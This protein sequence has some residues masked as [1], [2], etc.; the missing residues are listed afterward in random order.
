MELVDKHVK[1]SEIMIDPFNPRYVDGNYDS[2]KNIIN[3]ILSKKEAY[4]L[5][6][7]MQTKVRWVNRIVLREIESLSIEKKSKICDSDGYKYIIVEGNTRLAC[8]KSGQIDGYNNDTKIPVV[9]TVRDK[10]EKQENFELEI[11]FIQAMANIMIVKDWEEIPKA[12]RIYDIFTIKKELQPNKKIREIIIDISESTGIP[13]KEVTKLINRYSIFNELKKQHCALDEKYWGF[14]EAFERS[15]DSKEF[16]GMIPKTIEFEWNCEEKK[17]IFADEKLEI[18]RNIPEIIKKA[19]NQDPNSKNFRDA[20]GN[21][22]KDE[23]DFY[24]RKEIIDKLMDERYYWKD[25]LKRNSEKN[26]TKEECRKKLKQA[27]KD[28]DTFPINSDWAYEF[29]DDLQKINNKIVKHLNIL[30]EQNKD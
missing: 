7:S 30:N 12:K 9:I 5:L 14:L 15:A 4:E 10:E 29:K 8:L 18:F 27:Y 13:E 1:I 3:K 20:F 19:A 28:I 22:L 21:I 23:K 26:N 25:F 16:I 11:M 2:Q 24:N 17:Y 6:L